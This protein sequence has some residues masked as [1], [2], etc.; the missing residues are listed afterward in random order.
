M[1]FSFITGLFKKYN[2]SRH[3]LFAKAKLLLEDYLKQVHP[4]IFYSANQ[5]YLRQ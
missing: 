1:I 3:K 5:W 4:V 2:V